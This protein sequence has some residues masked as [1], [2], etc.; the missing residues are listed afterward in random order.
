MHELMEKGIVDYDPNTRKFCMK[1]NRMPLY[2]QRGECLYEAAIRLNSII[3]PGTHTANLVTV[4]H[5]KYDDQIESTTL[6]NSVAKFYTAQE[7]YESETDSD[8]EDDGPYWKYALHT[9]RQL[10]FPEVQYQYYESEA[11]DDDGQVVAYPAT[12]TSNKRTTEARERISKIPTKPAKQV[13]DG[14][15]PP[16]RKGRIIPPRKTESPPVPQQSQ[17]T[18]ESITP[19]PLPTRRSPTVEPEPMNRIS[20][21]IEPMLMPLPQPTP[22]DVRRLRPNQDISMADL[23]ETIPARAARSAP[24]NAPPHT[25]ASREPTTRGPARQSE[26]SSQVETGEVVK[27]ILN[28]E[29]TLPLRTIIGA[30]REIAS[31]FNDAIKLK[32]T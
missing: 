26:V 27:E 19:T 10:R 8:S 18:G 22:I 25:T 20:P 7:G 28:T 16:P 12:R 23:P 17:P 11:E 1:K 31:K 14:V 30:S 24:R 6:Q 5:D 13:F 4:A 3:V 9:K 29:I 32:N 2:R 15:Y 21:E